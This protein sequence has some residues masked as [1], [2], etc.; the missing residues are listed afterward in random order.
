MAALVKFGKVMVKV[1][2][3]EHRPPLTVTLWLSSGIA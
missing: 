1:R 3:N 2:G